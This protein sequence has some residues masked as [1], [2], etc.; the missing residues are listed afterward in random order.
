MFQ[1]KEDL[2]I[3]PPDEK[4]SHRIYKEG[5]DAL[6]NGEFFFAAQKFSEAEKILP[7]IEHSAKIIID[8]K[9]LLLRY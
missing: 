8:V 3:K 2:S 7:I 6:N 1:K 4:E 5:L 9:L